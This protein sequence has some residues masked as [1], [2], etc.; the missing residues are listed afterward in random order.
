MAQKLHNT[1]GLHVC[2]WQYQQLEGKVAAKSKNFGEVMKGTKKIWLF[3]VFGLLA[4]NLYSLPAEARSVTV[5]STTAAD[6]TNIGNLAGLST[7]LDIVGFE[8]QSVTTE[9]I[10][11]LV[12]NPNVE[13]RIVLGL[14]SYTAGQNCV[15]SVCSGPQVKTLNFTINSE[16]LSQVVNLTFT[17]DTE[18]SQDPFTGAT[19]RDFGCLSFN[20]GATGTACNGGTHVVSSFLP[21]PFVF[22]YG[23]DSLIITLLQPQNIK[24]SV[25]ETEITYEILASIQLIPE[26]SSLPL[27]AIGLAAWT[28]AR[29]RKALA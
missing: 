7:T 16:G 8:G 15:G 6:I 2:D 24:Q 9:L 3:A 4:C 12:P 14:L 22:N 20:N 25:D 21:S 28:F 13:Q 23:F 1:N 19:T 27:L 29:K 10:P 26:P 17:W 5:Q 11:D 18:V